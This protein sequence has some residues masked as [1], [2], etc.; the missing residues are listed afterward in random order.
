MILQLLIK[1]TAF[2]FTEPFLF[3]SFLLLIMHR[4]KLVFGWTFFLTVSVIIGIVCVC[5]CVLVMFGF[6]FSSVF[7]CRGRPS[8]LA[9]PRSC[10]DKNTHHHHSGPWQANTIQ[11]MSTSECVC[12]CLSVRVRMCL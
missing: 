3:S 1:K 9:S 6:F 10:A 5:V 4:K 11:Q 2:A 8:L 12:V 7:L